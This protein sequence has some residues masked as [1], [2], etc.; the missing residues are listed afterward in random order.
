MKLALLFVA[1][2][3]ATFAFTEREYAEAFYNW[4]TQYGKVYKSFAESKHRFSV[5]RY[6]YDFVNTWD[7]EARGFTV[8]I[9]EFADQTNEEFSKWACGL[10]ISKTYEPLVGE[11]QV[12]VPSSWDWRTKGA[13]THV[14]NQ[15]QCGSCWS[16]SATGSTEGAYFL[17][18]HSLTSL[19]EQNL[20][21]CST[22][23]GNQGCQGGLMDQ[24]FQYIISNSGIDTEASYPYTA[25]GP[26]QCQFNRNN[27][28]ATLSS[29]HDIPS[30]S[31][32]SL[33]TA[34]AKTPVSVAIDASHSSFQFYSG[35]VY[36]EPACSSTQ[37]DHG[38][39]AIGWGVDG[40]QDFWL[41][42]NSW[43]TG[44]GM[45]GY[46][47][48]TRNGGNQCGIATAASYPIV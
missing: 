19:S 31:E 14:K 15:G 40:G 46:I 16:F 48:M 41:V 10:N 24:A 38:V 12:D 20:V 25:T 5:F 4:Q 22:A 33:L 3:A 2:F 32:S 27:V 18:G 26:N 37:L 43:G 13:V 21:D 29:F 7:P 44:W 39:L 1:L 34:V 36:N 11:E 9:N 47:E 30:G 35:G 6:N 42:K 17:A 45:A 23:Q 8:A 28:G